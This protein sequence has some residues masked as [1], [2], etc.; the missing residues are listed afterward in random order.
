MEHQFDET[1]TDNVYNPLLLQRIP[2]HFP[3]V[4]HLWSTNAGS[5]A[6]YTLSSQM[7]T[8][9]LQL[10]KALT[11]CCVSS[12]LRQHLHISWRIWALR[13][14]NAPLTKIDGEHLINFWNSKRGQGE[15][16]GTFCFDAFSKRALWRAMWR[17]WALSV[18]PALRHSSDTSGG[19]RRCLPSPDTQHLKN[20][21]QPFCCHFSLSGSA[22]VFMLFNTSSKNSCCKIFFWTWRVNFPFHKVRKYLGSW[23][24]K[25]AFFGIYESVLTLGKPLVLQSS[26]MRCFNGQK[27]FCHW[28][29]INCSLA[30]GRSGRS[31]RHF[32]GNKFWVAGDFWT[33]TAGS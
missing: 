28:N 20:K 22:S 5:S 21:Q 18:P 33:L 7:V 13:R 10:I 29:W 14:R 3:D 8:G 17:D 25:Q 12:E 23:L 31:A 27:L 6:F 26:L 19:Q 1:S 15:L 11:C 9:F 32:L 24:Y 2:L 30:T 16:I 4:N